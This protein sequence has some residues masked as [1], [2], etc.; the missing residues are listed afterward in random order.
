MCDTFVLFQGFPIYVSWYVII[1]VFNS[2]KPMYRPFPLFQCFS[3]ITP[4]VSELL[5]LWTLHVHPNMFLEMQVSNLNMFNHLYPQFYFLAYMLYPFVDLH[6][7]EGQIGYGILVCA[8]LD[9]LSF[10]M[11][12]APF[13]EQI[14]FG[15]QNGLLLLAHLFLSKSE[16]P[17]RLLNLLAPGYQIFE[18][19]R[20]R[21]PGSKDLYKQHIKLLYDVNYYC[22]CPIILILVVDDVYSYMLYCI[23]AAPS[24]DVLGDS[25]VDTTASSY[26]NQRNERSIDLTIKGALMEMKLFLYGKVS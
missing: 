16:F 23:Q 6:N 13:Y 22:C 11:P 24:V 15:I 10:E 18:M 2:I 1:S 19:K 21:L 25:N 7:F 20:K 14:M 5:M 4:F 3:F 8:L 9:F 12:P 26:V 17:C